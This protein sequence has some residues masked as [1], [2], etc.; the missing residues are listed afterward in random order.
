MLRQVT[1]YQCIV[2]EGAHVRGGDSCKAHSVTTS[3]VM[4]KLPLTLSVT[5]SV[6][7]WLHS[8][9]VF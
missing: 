2:V 8:N 6:T 1:T 4:L 5:V 7:R 3:I 9:T